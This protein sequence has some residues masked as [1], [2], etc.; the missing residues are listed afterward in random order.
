MT[1]TQTCL[2]GAAFLMA[3]SLSAR[4]FRNTR[5]KGTLE[6]LALF[7]VMGGLVLLDWR[8]AIAA[9]VLDNILD[10]LVAIVRGH[11]GKTHTAATCRESQILTFTAMLFLLPQPFTWTPVLWL[12]GVEV[13][14]LTWLFCKSYWG[15][16]VV[17]CACMAALVTTF[18]LHLIH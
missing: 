9:Q 18:H 6:S 10:T 1:L 8:V 3:L 2:I 14:L 17:A 16:A 12:L 11:L 13:L 15:R 7:F 5:A 4:I